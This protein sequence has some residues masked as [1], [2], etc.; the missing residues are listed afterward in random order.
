[1]RDL[2]DITLFGNMK[3]FAMALH[4]MRETLKELEKRH[5]RRQKQSL[6]LAAVDAYCGAIACLTRDLGAANLHS[7][8]LL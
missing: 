3:A 6:F 4:S 8:G 7:R 5:Y 2:E 1:M